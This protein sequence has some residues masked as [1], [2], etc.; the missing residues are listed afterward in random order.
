M[1]QSD[2]AGVIGNNENVL[3]QTKELFQGKVDLK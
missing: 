3:Q 1:V 2:N